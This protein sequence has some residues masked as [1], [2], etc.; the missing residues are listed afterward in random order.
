MKKQLLEIPS[1]D[2]ST[3]NLNA[4]I[5]TPRGSRNKYAFDEKAGLFGLK[6]ILPAGMAFPFDF[7]FIPSTLAA[8]GDPLDILIV[9]EEKLFPGCLVQARLLGALKCKQGK[10]GKLERND[11]LIA[12]PILED[13]PVK[14]RSLKGLDA[15]MLWELEKF[16]V[17]QHTLVGE[18]FKVV[19]IIGPHKASRLVKRAQ[20]SRLGQK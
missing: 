3:G 2:P 13:V 19:E 5:E 1:I 14:I 11:R 10:K 7:G 12:V 20:L 9:T 16:F 8:D 4:I 15:K 6:K 18:E 17:Y